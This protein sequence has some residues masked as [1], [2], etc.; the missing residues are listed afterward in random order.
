VSVGAAITETLFALGVGDSI[1][2]V[3]RTSVHP[4]AAT[5][6]PK[7]GLPGQL[8]VE[9]IASY[10]P[11]LIIADGLSTHGPAGPPNPAL[12]QL[13]SLGLRV[14][15][16]GAEPRTPEDAARRIE[17]IGAI[18]GKPSEAKA[19]STTMLGEVNAAKRRLATVTTRPKVLFVYARG[20]RTLLVSGTDTTAHALLTLA[21]AHNAVT[22]YA[23]F[24]PMS[25]ESVIA[26]APDVVVIPE[27][28]LASLG[29]VDG[30][31]ALPGL[32]DTPAGKARRFV[33]I[34]DLELLSFG[35]RLGRGLDKLVTALHG[36]AS[37]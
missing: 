6:L 21:G 23:D 33:A 4:E 27:R 36:D 19:L 13:A 35:P 7:V 8:S 9:G 2:A 10:E 17:T 26:A 31:M 15:R 1:V 28:G 37:P 30:L 25:A 18:V 5:A 14:E 32:A 12:D 22:A 24:K 16:L 11:T 3:D 20:H 34:D 29:G